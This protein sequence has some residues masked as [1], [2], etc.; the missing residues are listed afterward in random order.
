[1]GLLPG[2]GKRRARIVVIA[3]ACSE[4]D[5]V[6]VDMALASK[7]MIS[8]CTKLKTSILI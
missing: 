6:V 8:L 7:R 5:E 2:A 4:V 1:M 3:V